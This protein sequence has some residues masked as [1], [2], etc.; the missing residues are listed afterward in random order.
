MTSA[1]LFLPSG[2]VPSHLKLTNFLFF[3]LPEVKQAPLSLRKYGHCGSTSAEYE[4]PVVSAGVEALIEG[5]ITYTPS[6]YSTQ[7]STDPLACHTRS[8]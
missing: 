6:E 8:V 3:A 5:L 1:F 7:P 2:V 4:R